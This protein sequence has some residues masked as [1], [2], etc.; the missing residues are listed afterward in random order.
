MRDRETI[1]GLMEQFAG[2]NEQYRTQKY[3]LEV[4]LDIRELLQKQNE[5]SQI[6]LKIRDVSETPILSKAIE[7]SKTG[8]LNN[9]L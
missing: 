4:L 2:Q 7:F 1:V 5:S 6:V 3:I 8:K 9:G